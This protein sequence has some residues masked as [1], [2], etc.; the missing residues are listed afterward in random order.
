ITRTEE[1]SDGTAAGGV[2]D[3]SPNARAKVKERSTDKLVIA[4]GPHP[5]PVPELINLTQSAAKEKV[6]AVGLVPG[7]VANDYSETVAEGVV[8]DYTTKEQKPKGTAIALSVS[9]GPRPRTVP[10]VA[11]KT[12]DQAAASLAQVGL[13]AVRADAFSDT[14]PKDQVIGTT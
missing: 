11:G 14:V 7:N 6:S 12:Y 1:F 4:N 5:A 2:I 8:L 10:N 13:T 9:A 3:Q